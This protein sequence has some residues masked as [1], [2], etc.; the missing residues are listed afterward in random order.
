M[1]PM[2]DIA[3]QAIGA[4]CEYPIGFEGLAGCVAGMIVLWG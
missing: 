2:A 1:M 3:A 4:T